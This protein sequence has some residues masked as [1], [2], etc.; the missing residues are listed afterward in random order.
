MTK[1]NTD[2]QKLLDDPT[3]L[4]AALML[5]QQVDE[6]RKA[7][8]KNFAQHVVDG[9]NQKLRENS[10]YQKPWGASL[11]TD[12][13]LI[14]GIGIDGAFGD[15][16][17]C[18]AEAWEGTLI[19]GW[20]KAYANQD[21]ANDALRL[22]MAQKL[23]GKSDRWWLCWTTFGGPAR[24]IGSAVAGSAEGLLFLHED[25]RDPNHPTAQ[26]LAQE[27]WNFFEPFQE[28]MSKPGRP[29]DNARPNS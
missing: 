9:L 24:E 28:R 7:I 26:H 11:E 27:L 23:A 1:P 4:E 17:R 6:K 18:V 8:Q 15:H 2:I 5:A 29:S 3:Q 10:L 19:V 16:S 21:F 22:E 14:V 25:N 13:G 12:Q 20:R